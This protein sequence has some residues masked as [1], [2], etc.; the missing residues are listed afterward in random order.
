MMRIRLSHPLTLKEIAGALNN[1]SEDT[2]TLIEY[3]STDTRELLR[4]DLFVALSGIEESGEKYTHRARS[5]GAYVVARDN[6][7][8]RVKDGADALLL[9]AQ[10]YKSKLK[11]LV[12]T[13]AVTGS[14]GKTTLKD[15]LFV[16]LSEGY[17]AH[18]TEK[19]YNNQIGLALTVLSAPADTEILIVE[20]GMNHRGEIKMLAEAIRPDVAI[21]TN[22]KD[23]HIGN[24]GSREEIARAKLEIYYDK[25]VRL[26]V[27]HD[28]P[29]FDNISEKI[30]VSTENPEAEIY[31]SLLG[32]ND[33]SSFFDV[34]TKDSCINSLK[35]LLTGRAYME[36]LAFSVA[37]CE[38]LS[39]PRERLIS[40]ISKLSEGIFRRHSYSLYDYNIIDD[41]Y[42]SS[43]DA[44]IYELQRASKHSPCS[45]V[46]GDML[47][48]GVFSEEKHRLIGKRAYELGFRYIY[49]FGKYAYDIADGAIMAGMMRKNIHVNTNLSDPRLTA[50]A[51]YENSLKGETLLFKGSHS[52]HC[53]KIIEALE[54]IIKDREK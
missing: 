11:N 39:L 17:K 42:S 2:R 15:M 6:A 32:E 4:G 26:I 24:L 45:C 46:L 21:I 48:L 44:A 3:I 53:E 29:L 27:A 12:K 47:E 49:A 13:V 40:G 20:M 37:V 34:F 31:L 38:L 41:T 54:S 9:L 36:A 23:A 19:N 16:I 1:H 7:D 35:A 43:P 33:G 18:K 8:I 14:V 28:E 50:E 5:M 10:Y 51:I 22:I 25:N 30:T 52:T